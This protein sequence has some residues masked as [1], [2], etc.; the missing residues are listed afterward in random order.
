MKSQSLA[1]IFM[2]RLCILKIVAL[3]DKSIKVDARIDIRLTPRDLRILVRA[4]SSLHVAVLRA[5]SCCAVGSNDPTHTANRVAF[6]TKSSKLTG[7][8]S[9]DETI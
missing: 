8:K 7:L 3:S 9:V 4:I 5:G 6:L 2:R 1:P